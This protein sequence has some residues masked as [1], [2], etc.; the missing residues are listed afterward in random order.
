VRRRSVSQQLLLFLWPFCSPCSKKTGE[1]PE[2]ISVAMRDPLWGHAAGVI[3]LYVENV[4]L[5][6]QGTANVQE[7]LLVIGHYS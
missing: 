3:D 5:T 4:P 6:G 2:P 1:A 7:V